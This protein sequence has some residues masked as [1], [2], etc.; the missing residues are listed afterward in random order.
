M[1]YN[2]SPCEAEQ[3]AFFY[4]SCKT[5]NANKVS[6]TDKGSKKTQ[7]TNNKL[8]YNM[9]REKLLFCSHLPS[10]V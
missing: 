5:K 2:T 4:T 8:H 7:K 6:R 9:T 10:P 3:I 1:L